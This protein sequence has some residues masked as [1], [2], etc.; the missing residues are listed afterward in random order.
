MANR[1]FDARDEK[2]ANPHVAIDSLDGQLAQLASSSAPDGDAI[3][4]LRASWTVLLELLAI[5]RPHEV[6][7]CP[8]CRHVGMRAATRCGH[9]WAKLSPPAAEDLPAAP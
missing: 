3:A 8:S 7:V 1:Y 6:R 2:N 9:C 4:K 5:D